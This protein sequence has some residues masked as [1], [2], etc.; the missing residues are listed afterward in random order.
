MQKPN[1][2]GNN[3]NVELEVTLQEDYRPRFA[4]QEYL[5]ERIE[6]FYG[7]F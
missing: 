5:L 2:T 6:R 3:V 1:W 4:L 7:N